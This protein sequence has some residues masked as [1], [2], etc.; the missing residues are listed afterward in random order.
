M[1]EV[2]GRLNRTIQAQG[3]DSLLV[4]SRD[5]L[6]L[7]YQTISDLHE[8]IGRLESVI[9]DYGWSPDEITSI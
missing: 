7:A 3:P 5:A 8:K 2:I 9:A 4:E 1:S 6:V